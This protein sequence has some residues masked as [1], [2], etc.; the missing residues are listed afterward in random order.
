MEA[1]GEHHAPA[2]LMPSNNRGIECS[3]GGVGARIGRHAV[4]DDVA[5]W[6]RGILENTAFPHLSQEISPIL[7]NPKVRYRVHNSSATL[8]SYENYK[9]SVINTVGI[10]KDGLL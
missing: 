10:F 8:V 3:V 2:D 7:W 5:P 6:N 4:G 1:I 9:F